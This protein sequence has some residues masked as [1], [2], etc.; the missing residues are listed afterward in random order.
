M[1]DLVMQ[2]DLAAPP[3]LRVKIQ[4]FAI[5]ESLKFGYMAPAHPDELFDLGTVVVPPSLFKHG[6]G[7]RASF[8]KLCGR[9]M[10]DG[11][12]RGRGSSQSVPLIGDISIAGTRVIARRGCRAIDRKIV[13]RVILGERKSA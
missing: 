6:S 8:L 12:L 5:G 11:S 2:I 4:G 1:P 9:A 3:N 7:G 10:N 13:I